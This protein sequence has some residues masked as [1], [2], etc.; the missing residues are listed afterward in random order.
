MLRTL[1]VAGESVELN[2]IP[3]GECRV[4]PTGEAAATA[5]AV[6]RSGWVVSNDEPDTILYEAQ[7]EGFDYQIEYFCR[8]IVH[9]RTV[10]VNKTADGYVAVAWC[11][12]FHLEQL[13]RQ[14]DGRERQLNLQ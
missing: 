6:E 14:N 11:D 3:E 13:V 12:S 1:R 2:P 10:F 9:C 4:A 5:W 7:V 8:E